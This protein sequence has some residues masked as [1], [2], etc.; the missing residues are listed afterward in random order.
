MTQKKKRP[1]TLPRKQY[2]TNYKLKAK[3]YVLRIFITFP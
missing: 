2:T 3:S 1:Q